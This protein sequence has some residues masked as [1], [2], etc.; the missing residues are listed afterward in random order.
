MKHQPW[1]MGAQPNLASKSKVMSISKCPLPKNTNWGF[2]EFGAQ[3]T[4]K[5]ST[6]F[7]TSALDT[8]YLRNETSYRQTKMLVSIYNVSPK[9]WPTFRDLWLRNVWHPLRH[10]DPPFG[11]HYVATIKVATCL[12]LYNYLK[13]NLCVCV[14]L[15]VCACVYLQGQFWA[16]LHEIWHVVSL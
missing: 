1:I 9:C 3:K 8:A 14:R 15:C 12:V 7:G 2:R 11:G 5:F 13:L 10:C 4:W 6:F 16:N